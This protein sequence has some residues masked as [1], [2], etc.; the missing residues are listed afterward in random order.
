MRH[1]SAKTRQSFRIG[2]ILFGLLAGLI[3]LGGGSARADV[4]AVIPIRLMAVVALGYFL[5]RMPLDTW[6][7]H[8][9][10]LFFIL[11]SFLMIAVQLIPLP[12]SLWSSL[13]GRQSYYEIFSLIGQ[14]GLWRPAS[15]APDFTLNSLLAVLP[16]AA[17][18]VGV[19]NLDA[20]ARRQVV[21]G[22]LVV[23]LVSGLL[24][25]LQVAGGANSPLRYYR[26]HSVEAGPG[27]LANRNHQAVLLAMGIPLL[28][29]WYQLQGGWVKAGAAR[30]VFA[31]SALA[32]IIVSVVA[33]QSRLGLIVVA[34]SV[35]LAGAFL[36]KDRTVNLRRM[37]WVAA[38]AAMAAFTLGLA[39]VMVVN[40]RFALDT[41]RGDLRYQSF[42]A[43]IAA[44]KAFFPL[45]AGFGTFADV[46]RR[47]EE[48]RTLQPQYLNHAHNDLV[49]L[50][51]EGGFLA[52]AMLVVFIGWVIKRS[53]FVWLKNDSTSSSSSLQLARLG[54][55]LVFLAM[56]GS[57]TDYPLRTPLIA[58]CFA[59]AAALLAD[60][61][62]SRQRQQLSQA[63]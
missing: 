5:A 57:L 27:F 11:A 41:L 4:P 31:S 45:G 21:T 28:A 2:Y 46:Y 38:Y 54:T 49:E 33:T 26:I 59:L 52:L 37:H 3:I 55:I 6:R 44:L 10:A 32:F 39:V 58:S 51:F 8:R 61:R 15:L 53:L 56:V 35:V 1:F 43:S 25:M 24:G 30:K 20:R 14:Q 7:Q 16:P 17:I 50:I 60:M 22:L 34:L 19:L 29:W 23:V 63:R 48:I 12:P 42:D 40:G 13:P 62:N 18:F 47:F 36:L 9:A